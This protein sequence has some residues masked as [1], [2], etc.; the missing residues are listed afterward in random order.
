MAG[1]FNPADPNAG[2]QMLSDEQIANQR[3]IADAMM[4]N[5]GKPRPMTHW[6][7]A[8]AQGV[9]GAMAGYKS[10]EA[11]QAEKTSNNTLADGIAKAFGGLGSAAGTAEGAVAP[12]AAP[13]A[14]DTG[15]AGSAT[16]A[17]AG[18][19]NISPE[20]KDGLAQSAAALK[21]DPVDL[22]TLVSYETAGTF[23]PTKAGPRTQWGQHRG[24]IQ[25]GEPQAKEHGV[26]WANPVKSQLGPDGAIV[27]Y[28]QKNGAQ[29]GMGLL[30]LYSIV[31]AGGPG[32]YNAS[33]AKNG[34][35]PGT[36]L[37][38]VRD[39]MAGHRAKAMAIFGTPA[40]APAPAQSVSTVQVIPG[41]DPAKLEADAAA[42]E[43][44][45]P[46]AARQL[47][48]RAGMARS[49]TADLPATGASPAEMTGAGNG[50]TIPGS[51]IQRIPIPPMVTGPA[52]PSTD[53]P[54]DMP[55]MA[56]AAMPAT[57][58]A[59]QP[60]EMAEGDASPFP[61][62]GEQTQA[63][64]ALPPVFT[65]EGTGQPWFNTATQPDP[66]SRVTQALISAKQPPARPADL[67]MATPQADLPAPGAVPAVGQLPAAVPQ[68]APRMPDLT[69]MDSG[70]A[71]EFAVAEGQR[72]LGQPAGDAVTSITQ[73]LAS[74]GIAPAAARPTSDAAAKVA[75]VMPREATTGQSASPAVQAV[76]TMQKAAASGVNTSDP[77]FAAG[78]A[79]IRRGD[80]AAGMALVTE[81]AKPQ[82][83]G[84]QVVGDQMYRTDPRTGQVSPVGVE[85]PVQPVTVA[86]GSNL[87]DPRTG[88]VVYKGGDGFRDLTDPT[89]RQRRGI[90]PVDTKPYQVG[91]DNR[92]HGVGSG[93]TINVDTK[94]AGK[95][96]EKANEIQAKRYGEMA[97][98]SDSARQMQGDLDMLEGMSRG[99]ATGRG[100]ETRLAMAQFAKAWGFDD[101]ASGLT[102][103]KLPEMEAFTSLIDKLT[104]QMRQGMPGAASDRDVTIF[105]NAL[106]SM[107]KTPDGNQ[108]VMGTLRSMNDYKMRQGDIATQAL[109]G[110]ISQAEADKAV[111]SLESPFARFK[112]YRAGLDKPASGGT[113]GAQAAPA[114][115][116]EPRKSVGGKSYVK[117]GNE[118]F[119][120]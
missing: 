75:S 94:G 42:Y 69:S 114:A 87:V 33:D 80:R 104:P 110:E 112:E 74:R 43:R 68:A 41:D 117:R 8:L 119:Q 70:G 50:F 90:D 28:F 6:A 102:G 86:A 29:P 34:G 12:A 16:I 22:A 72:R 82:Q 99:I 25:F 113:A 85:K 73:A 44:S 83:Y 14:A 111:R 51:D 2:E 101:I 23:D 40:A 47:R 58:E 118:W 37:D 78:I 57:E 116:A 32:R 66:A 24:L 20:I 52:G 106:P 107:L 71:R 64:G 19:L 76:A 45:N 79:L 92:V 67:A 36:V 17:G 27:K 93:Q 18:P 89:E 26:D 63:N 1:W 56:R 9:E 35:A 105:R 10:Y 95:F 55:P 46:E 30:D 108:I 77:R 65:S 15:P 81:S 88:K 62:P 7:Q 91:P 97:D 5:A 31:N 100:A 103:G 53:Q 96:T 120:E 61:Q 84:F 54:M 11:D 48:A 21:V 59:R 109:R 60:W 39:Q 115:Q 3:R 13:V 4:R 49:Q 38:K 98:A